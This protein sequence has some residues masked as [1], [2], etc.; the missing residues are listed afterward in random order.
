MMGC[1]EWLVIQVL[2][3]I[4][5]LLALR[6][7]LAFLDCQVPKAHGV[8]LG[9][10]GSPDHLG[11]QESQEMKDQWGHQGPQDAMGQGRE[12][13]CGLPGTSWNRRFNG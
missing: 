12:R 2:K 13:R 10:L 11:S 6:E 4:L 8:S 3:V 7:I 5:D 1:L 9:N